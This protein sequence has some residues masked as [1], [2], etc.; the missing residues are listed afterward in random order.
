[1]IINEST[2]NSLADKVDEI[3]SKFSNDNETT[4][5]IFGNKI[6][7]DLGNFDE[8]NSNLKNNL[9]TAGLKQTS[10]FRFSN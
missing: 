9:K 7:V 3:V 10:S 4:V 1:M 2:Y 5:S 6:I 8:N